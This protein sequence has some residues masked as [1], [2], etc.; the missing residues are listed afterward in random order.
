MSHPSEKALLVGVSANWLH[1]DP[2]RTVYNGR[3]L[4]Y[5]EQSMGEWLLDAGAIPV[6][7]PAARPGRKVA[8]SAA[9]MVRSFDAL[10]IAGGADVWPGSYGQN[11]LRPEWSGD[12]ARDR[13]ERAL[14][15]AA[16][17]HDRPLLGICRGHQMLNVA[18]GGTL[19]QDIAT[20]V[21]GAREHRSAER[22]HRLIHPVRLEEGGW[23]HRLYGRQEALI[24]SVHHQ[25][26]QE[27]APALR[28][29]ARCPE[30]GIIEGVSYQDP[31]RW[32]VGVQWH[33]EFQERSQSDLLA[34]G[35]LREDFLDAARQR[36]SAR[37]G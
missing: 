32:V 27:L 5:M 7:L 9:Q 10:I 13:V 28:V 6:M 31:S 24:N 12:R 25:A 20:Q 35:P 37:E 3:T 26:I 11:A 36:R 34:T 21:E 15:E 19:F 4:L 8:V 14:I 17:E 29:S 16:I 30:D 2:A 33:P 23:L 18:L 1:A 22:Y